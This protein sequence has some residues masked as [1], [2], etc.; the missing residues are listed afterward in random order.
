MSRKQILPLLA[1]IAAAMSL[2]VPNAIAS[3][4]ATGMTYG[5]PTAKPY[6]APAAGTRIFRVRAGSHLQFAAVT[7]GRE[8]DF[9]PDLAA[10]TRQREDNVGFQGERIVFIWNGTAVPADHDLN[11]AC[12]AAQVSSG[13][14]VLMF[15]LRPDR[16]QWPADQVSLD[17]FN[18]TIDA[19]DKQIFWGTG[20]NGQ[21]C[22]PATAPPQQFMWM[23]GNEPNSRDFCNGDGST[24]DLSGIHKVCAQREV[25][26]LHSSYGFIKGQNP[27]DSSGQQGKYGHLISVVGGGLSSHD[28]PF[29]LLRQF[30]T[31]RK[32]NKTCDMDYFG[33]HPYALNS[34]DPYGGFGLEPQIEAMLKA[35]GCPLKI[36][37]TEMGV[38]TS[39][40]NLPGY[41]Y[42]GA[43]NCTQF[44][45]GPGALCVSEDAFVATF[46]RFI[47]IMQ[48][49]P[50]VVGFMN[51]ELDDEQNFSG[52]Q[53]GVDYFS[54]YPKSFVGA[55][56]PI[57]MA[58]GNPPNAPPAS[59]N[60]R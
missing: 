32:G 37:Y 23:I 58:I 21:P 47:Q 22:W 33:F 31:D 10:A 52:W 39:I 41:N 44:P 48:G 38:E 34:K 2:A 6:K 53:S 1:V 51:F 14:K 16:N 35:G 50:D 20:T 57:L 25:L 56:K 36:I 26:L 4:G 13:H 55:L 8:N 28:A 17:A 60:S 18:Q 11:A 27:Q 5:W 40:P 42:N 49:Q 29:D 15:N 59:G 12:N 3:N 24:N 9:T 46:Q 7:L 19:I 43:S 54:G 45:G 30:L